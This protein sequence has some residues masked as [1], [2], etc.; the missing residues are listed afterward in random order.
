ML[1][2]RIKTGMNHPNK[3]TTQTQLTYWQKPRVASHSLYK[4][5]LSKTFLLF[6]ALQWLIFS[7]QLQAQCDATVSGIFTYCNSF[8]NGAPLAGYFV[9]FRVADPT[10]A[11]LNV[12]DLN[13][14]VPTNQGKRV[15]VNDANEPLDFSIA[16]LSIGGGADSLEFWYFGP[17]PNGSSFNVVLVDPSNVCDTI[18]VAS[19]TYSCA[20]QAEGNTDPFACAP[21]GSGSPVALCFLD[22]SNT[23]FNLGTPMLSH[24]NTFFTM[25]RP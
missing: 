13:G 21:P 23:E 25:N 18:F 10:G 8:H 9:G 6:I 14:N 4:L 1:A 19:G 11:T 15:N 17:F 20:D 12:V 22:F 16:Q 3:H 7:N 24:S 2:A 5:P